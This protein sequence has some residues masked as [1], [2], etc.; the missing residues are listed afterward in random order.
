MKLLFIIAFAP[1]ISFLVISALPK[2]LKKHASLIAI[3][4]IFLS[5]LGTLLFSLRHPEFIT[6]PIEVQ[7]TWMTS[8]SLNFNFGFLL[9]R[10]NI[11][12][13]FIVTIV[14]FF[15]QVFSVSY[16]S[17]EGRGK[18]R[19]FAFLSFFSF[20]MINLVMSNNLLQTFIFWELVGVA[21][22]LLIGFWYHKPSAAEASRKAFVVT[23]LG[24][25]GFY[26]AVAL[27][28]LHVGNLNFS[29]LNSP[30]IS[31]TLSQGMITLFTLLIFSGIAGKSAQFPLHIWLPDAMEGPTPVSAL[32]HSATMVAAGVFLTARNYAFFSASQTAMTVILIFGT[33]TAL[34]GATLGVVQN[35]IKRILAYSTI[36][37][38]GLMMMGLGAGSYVG[39]MFH[40]ATH[41]FFKSLLFLCAGSLIHH[42][43]T[44]DIWE[45]AKKGARSQKFSLF[46]LTIGGLSL[47]GFW[48][49]SGFWSKDL[50]LDALHHKPFFYGAG[51]T[52]SFFTSYYVFRL[53]FILFFRSQP[54]HSHA[55]GQGFLSFCM[56]LPLASLAI[57][58]II[59]G[60]MG[61]GLLH[62]KLLKFIAPEAHIEL[63]VPIA[64][65]G[66]SAALLGLILA[67]WNYVRKTPE[68]ILKSRGIRKVLD[69]K[70]YMDHLFEKIFGR[71]V[72]NISALLNWFDKQMINGKM[73]N[74]T[75]WQTFRLGGL[76]TKIQSGELQDY[77]MIL[78]TVGAAV[79]FFMIR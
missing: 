18:A 49:L 69:R 17:E 76:L 25:L 59:V 43:H 46:I 6:H 64:L 11:L 15:V 26:L 44:N 21:S 58:S 77:L 14:S 5:F 3:F 2:R 68:A 42:F 79:I 7:W 16:M 62:H 72:L 24:D 31:Q 32:I 74:G 34:L 61:T 38:L 75:A 29:H 54:S 35:D 20:S 56:N 39:G 67:Y 33:L 60:F 12:M 73:V 19:Y 48:P 71:A 8:S 50:I 4:S 41:A 66:T 65:S 9:D 30:Q 53:L 63:S 70:Y 78:F 10:L 22:Y 37:Q 40:L 55:H 28:A 23:R 47:A 13:L 1:L 57:G 45:M 27:L 51:L 52:V 36:S